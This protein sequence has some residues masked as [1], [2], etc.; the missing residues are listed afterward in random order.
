[1][2]QRVIVLFLLQAAPHPHPSLW[3]HQVMPVNLQ[4]LTNIWIVA[5]THAAGPICTLC[6]WKGQS[7]LRND[8]SRLREHDERVNRGLERNVNENV[9][10]NGN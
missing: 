1:M 10:G 3:T 9:K 7:F 8:R 5:T 4:G 2:R 6:P